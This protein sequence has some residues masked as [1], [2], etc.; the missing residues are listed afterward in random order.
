MLQCLLV[1]DVKGFWQMASTITDWISASSALG[2]TIIAGMTAYLA[3]KQYLR[4]LSQEAEPDAASDDTAA[5]KKAELVV[6]ETSKQRTKLTVQSRS[7]ECWLLNKETSDDRHQWTLGATEIRRILDQRDVIVTP[8]YRS[9]TGLFKMGTKR[10]WLYS[11]K[12]FPD[13]DY[14][15]GELHEILE[16]ALQA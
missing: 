1:L 14:L 2:A 12:L 16:T 3:Y 8:G 5:D 6:F 15:R 13:P 11:K 10:N 7:L 9:Q 4:P